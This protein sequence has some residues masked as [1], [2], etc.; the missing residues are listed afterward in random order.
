[1]R[2]YHLKYIC[3]Y[4][5]TQC[6]Y[7]FFFSK[8]IV[9]LFYSYCYFTLIPFFSPFS[10]LKYSPHTLQIRYPAIRLSI[11]PP[12]PYSGN[13]PFLTFLSFTTVT[14][15]HVLIRNKMK[16]IVSL[17]ET[18]VFL[19][20]GYLYVVPSI[21]L[22]T[23]CSF[24]FIIASINAPYLFAFVCGRLL[25]SLPQMLYCRYLVLIERHHV[26][27]IYV[28]LNV[29]FLCAWN[30]PHWPSGNKFKLYPFSPLLIP[31]LQQGIVLLIFAYNVNSP[32]KQ[33]TSY[34]KVSQ[35]WLICWDRK[36][37]GNSTTRN[38]TWAPAHGVL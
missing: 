25:L 28:N 2:K 16:L 7:W 26:L 10:L 3:I 38:L 14:P 11:V 17:C 32:Y 6:V 35:F 34:H 27:R 15:G 21:Y 30:W 37:F 5:Q 23:P 4:T 12:V 8:L 36:M 31:K 1:M 20:L 24:F 33:V 13:G 19:D 22:Q 18:F 9:W 29:F